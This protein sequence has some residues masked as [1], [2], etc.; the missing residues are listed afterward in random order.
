MNIRGNVIDVIILAG[1]KNSRMKGK[2]KG[3]LAFRNEVFLERI[4][5]S[6]RGEEG[7]I[8]LSYAS[9]EQAEIVPE[10]ARVIY[11]DLREVGPVAGLI[12][13]LK[14]GGTE[15]AAVCACDMP[16]ISP[17]LYEYLWEHGAR[18]EDGSPADVILPRTEDGLHPLA[19]LYRRG[20]LPALEEAVGR[21]Q[22]GLNR[23][24]REL[25]VVEVELEPLSELELAV[26]NIN[27][28]LE[29]EGLIRYDYPERRQ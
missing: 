18:T 19:A 22:F 20:I 28:V 26:T 24:L 9:P 4:V 11:D 14:A 29:Y 2:F 15:Y 27:T 3:S 6:F 7:E 1:G 17:S 25:N 10:G 16:F 23:I 5:R 21:G 12:S 8:L 13:G